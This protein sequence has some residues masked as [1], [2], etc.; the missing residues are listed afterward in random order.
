MTPILYRPDIQGLRAIAVLAVMLF[1]VNSAWLPGGFVGVDVFLVISGFLIVSI[2][3]NKKTGPSYRLTSTLSNFYTG[4]LK[5]IAPAYFVMLIVVSLLAAVLF[6]PPDL[7]IYKQGLNKAAWFNSNNYFASF[8]DYFAPAN[9]EQ[10]LLH[11]WSLAVEIQFYLL[12]PWLILLVPIKALKWLLWALLLGFTALAEYRLRALGLA[13]DTYY[14]LYARLPEFFAGGLVVLYMD[15]ANGGRRHPWLGGMW[16][17]LILA[18]AAIQ[19]R[20]G[21]FPGVPALLPVLGAALVLLHPAQGIAR[22]LLVSRPMAWL[23]KLSYSLYLWHWPVLAFLRYYTGAEVL[24]LPFSLLFA[25]LTLLLA[26]LSFYWVETP[27]RVRHTRTKQAL[28]CILLALAALGTSKSMAKINQALSPAP[29]P[30]EYQRYADPATICHGQIVGDCLK[31]DLTSTKEVLVLGDSHAAMLNIFFDRLG[32]ELGFK[33]R[34]ITASSCVTIPGFDYQRIG[35]WARKPCLEQ[36]AN[37]GE[38]LPKVKIIFLAA[39]WSW[40]FDS[41]EFNDALKEF[42]AKQSAIGKKIYLMEQEPLLDRNPQRALSFRALGL[43]P[44]VVISNKYKEVN[45]RLN[46]YMG[47]YPA[48]TSLNFEQ[49]GVFANIPFHQGELLYMDEHHLN[50]VGATRYSEMVGDAFKKIMN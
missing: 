15:A 6:L 46:D 44:E 14:G 38:Y 13:Q 18:A 8:G 48:V 9:H 1:H 32:K 10:T 20:L 42:L 25:A 35:E 33:A 39:F 27:L 40:Q 30:I 4:R 34:I 19:P 11:T 29:L 21:H 47:K 37:A 45:S 16:L 3:L 17:L 43:H 36:I 26:M 2:L 23:G 41:P 12:A 7:T 22:Q 50:E 31:G 28:A 24:D 5:R 49:T